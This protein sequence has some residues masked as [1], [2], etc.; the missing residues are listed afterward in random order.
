MRDKNDKEDLDQIQ[1]SNTEEMAKQL[2][3]LAQTQD[4]DKRYVDIFMQL[5][6][7]QVHEQ[8]EKKS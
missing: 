2:K 3:T 6:F 7:K 8:L 5:P 1:F 4:P